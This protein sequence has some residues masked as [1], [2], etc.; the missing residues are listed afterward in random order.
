MI[1]LLKWII[2][3]LKWIYDF[4]KAYLIPTFFLAFLLIIFLSYWEVFIDVF[5]PYKDLFPGVIFLIFFIR[6]LNPFL[7]KE[8]VTGIRFPETAPHEKGFADHYDKYLKDKVQK[9]EQNRLAALK[10]ARRL[11]FFTLP[12]AH[13]VPW[14][15]WKLNGFLY[16]ILWGW[17]HTLI[18][19]LGPILLLVYLLVTVMGPISDYKD[20]IKT[21]IFP[22]ILKFLGKFTY[23]INPKRKDVRQYDFMGFFPRYDRQINEDNIRGTYK[24]VKIDLF[25]TV[26]DRARK[27][28]DGEYY[29]EVFRGII[30]DLTFN[31]N[32]KGTTIIRKDSGLIGN[33]FHET[34]PELKDVKLEDPNFNKIFQAYSDDQVE[35]RYVLSVSFMERLKELSEA[36]GSKA[37]Q[38]CFYQEKVV[39]VIPIKKNMFEPGSIYV[40][41]NFIDDAK[42]L[43]KEMDLICKIV[44]ILNLNIKTN[45]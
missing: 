30:I 9:F 16:T 6:L 35:A 33:L 15:I 41:E 8:R 3:L 4:I 38:C 7:T 24:S 43:L 5:Y 31:K 45:L 23:A 1:D 21:E 25:E 36:F 44:N 17:L 28:Q 40:A 26:L 2:S 10:K 29:D 20:S 14:G 42:S 34:L 19:Y 18:V 11:F 39:F 32:L 27:S 13:F 12:I 37:V 22:N